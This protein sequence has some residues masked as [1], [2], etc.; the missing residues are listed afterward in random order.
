MKR[1]LVATSAAAV[2]ALCT[3]CKSCPAPAVGGTSGSGAGFVVTGGE[4]DRSHDVGSASAD[5]TASDSGSAGSSNGSSSA[6]Q[7]VLLESE[8]DIE[9]AHT[10]PESLKEVARSRNLGTKN[11]LTA[12]SFNNL[13]GEEWVN[14]ATTSRG[15]TIRYS[16]W[17]NDGT[18]WEPFLFIS[19]GTEYDESTPDSELPTCPAVP[20]PGIGAGVC[21]FNGERLVYDSQ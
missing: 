6:F 5:N 17:H 15:G 14:V 10:L 4:P 7:D 19:P 2:L 1:F 8:A 3:G 21:M 16:S 13:V 9:T 18:G 11:D 20:P 12:I